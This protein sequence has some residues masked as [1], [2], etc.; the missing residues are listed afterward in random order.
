MRNVR[1][2]DLS[3]LKLV[4]TRVVEAGDTYLEAG[5]SPKKDGRLC[6]T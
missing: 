3:G 2:T 4:M 1:S 6:G 5:V